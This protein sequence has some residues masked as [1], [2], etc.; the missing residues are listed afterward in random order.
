M[1]MNATKIIERMEKRENIFVEMSLF[2]FYPIFLK[3]LQIFL[4]KKQNR[5]VN[6]IAQ[7]FSKLTST[8][9]NPLSLAFWYIAMVVIKKLTTVYILLRPLASITSKNVGWFRLEKLSIKDLPPFLSF[10]FVNYFCALF[11][12]SFPYNFPNGLVTLMPI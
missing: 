12:T 1:E 9:T 10:K 11:F 4:F 3:P 7:L 8:L 6:K 2:S 5:N